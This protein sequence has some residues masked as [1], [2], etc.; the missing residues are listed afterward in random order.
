MTN[1]IKGSDRMGQDPRRARRVSRPRRTIAALVVATLAVLGAAC[2]GADPTAGGAGLEDPD[3]DPE[4]PGVEAPTDDAVT[5]PGGLR[6]PPLEVRN[7]RGYTYEIDVEIE[8]F[9]AEVRLGDPGRTKLFTDQRI[10]IAV[11]NLLDDR[12]APFDLDPVDASAVT[13]ELLFELDP[14]LAAEMHGLL[15]SDDAEIGPTAVETAELATRPF[16]RGAYPSFG[17]DL[18]VS[19]RAPTQLAA[20]E[21]AAWT[22]WTVDRDGLA[23]EAESFV[24]HYGNEY[25]WP[26]AVIDALAERLREPPTFVRVSFAESVLQASNCDLPKRGRALVHYYDV[27]AEFWRTPVE[28]TSSEDCGPYEYRPPKD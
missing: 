15:R 9:V 25:G 26:P 5:T 22:I 18:A 6:L 21:V 16:A 12:P 11:R 13:V 14:G 3:A 27:E 7:G 28:L 20:S 10:G 8:T 4:A 23:T 24:Q 2:G 1:T 19:G 17:S